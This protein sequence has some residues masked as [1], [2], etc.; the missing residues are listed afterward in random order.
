MKRALQKAFFNALL[1]F[2]A[3]TYV[4]ATV[5]LRLQMSS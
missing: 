1:P 5:L 2:D 4:N 3:I